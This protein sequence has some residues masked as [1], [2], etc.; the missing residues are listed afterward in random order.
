VS[1]VLRP[2]RL[3]LSQQ[4][5]AGGFDNVVSA[6]VAK[7]VYNGH[8]MYYQLHVAERVLWTVRVPN[9]DGRQKRFRSGEAA[10]V[11]WNRGESVVLVR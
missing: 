6:R 11:C 5:A 2:E 3:H 8:E 9:A 10:M 1:V 4:A 7:A